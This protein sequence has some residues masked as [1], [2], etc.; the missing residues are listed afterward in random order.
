[1]IGTV[2]TPTVHVRV[3]SV[4]G[5]EPDAQPKPP[6]KPVAVMQK[7][8]TLAWVLGAIGA[9]LLT[10]LS[11]CSS[12][13]GGASARAR[14]SPRRRRAPPW[15]IALEK[16]GA[17]RRQKPEL[18]AEG[19]VVELA[20][21]VSDVVREYLGAQYGFDGLESTTDEVVSHVRG[22]WLGGSSVAEVTTLLG[23]C[24]LVKFAKFT[25]DEAQCDSLLAGAAHVVEATMTRAAPP[26]AAGPVA[27]AH[28]GG[29]PPQGPQGPQGP[30]SGPQAPP[31]PP[32][33]PPPPQSWGGGT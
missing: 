26:P 4:L 13:A 3:G 16:L 29:P 21:R 19:R 18:I 31:P 1:M 7:D 25:P 9:L 12:R 22:V 6:S 11:R 10:A 5:N 32:A 33:A 23:D 2:S 24:D 27:H 8:Y 30:G 20:D 17:L 28:P 15:E 14:P